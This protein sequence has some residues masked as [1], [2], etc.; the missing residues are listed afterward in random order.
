MYAI[1]PELRE[2]LA[3]AAVAKICITY[4]LYKTSFRQIVHGFST[5][6]ALSISYDVRESKYYFEE[7]CHRCSRRAPALLSC[8]EITPSTAVSS[9]RKQDFKGDFKVQACAAFMT[10]STE[11]AMLTPF[12]RVQMLLLQD[13]KYHSKRPAIIFAFKGKNQI[14]IVG[15]ITENF[16]VLLK[17]KDHRH[18]TII[19]WQCECTRSERF[20]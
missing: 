4:P 18:Q 19:K 14:G 9:V 1:A 17:K 12:E 5:T 8:S 2:F 20:S 13:R 16:D 6:N 3:G 7:F 10:G 15:V 11:A